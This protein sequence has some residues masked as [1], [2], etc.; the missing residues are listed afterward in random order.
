MGVADLPL[1][2]DPLGR[3][4]KT[5]HTQPVFGAQTT[6]SLVVPAKALRCQLDVLTMHQRPDTWRSVDLV[7]GHAEQVDI[8]RT[9]VHLDLAKGLDRIG[10]DE[11][12]RA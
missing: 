10:V 4:A 6:P 2:G 11:Y 3:D 7:A 5:V 1:L 9:K 12:V 8:P